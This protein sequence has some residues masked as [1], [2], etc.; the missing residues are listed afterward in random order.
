MTQN[1]PLV[2]VIILNYNGKKFLDDCFSSVLESTYPNV[3]TMML[4]NASTD[5]SVAY[6][7]AKYPA[8]KIVENPHNNGYSNGYNL[9]FKHAKGKYFVLLNN[10]VKVAKDWLEPL[11]EAAEQDEEIAAL[12]P[13]LVSMIDPSNFE[14][15]GASGGMM[16]RYGYP[17]T[18]GR[19]FD[20][21]EKDEGQYDD[22]TEIF[23]ASGAALFLRADVIKNCGDLDADFVHHMEEIDFCWRMHLAGYKI[24]VVPKSLVLHYG[25]A[26]ISPDS[27]KKM[28]WNHRNSTFMLFKNVGAENFYR[29]LFMKWWLD[30]IT[31]ST[32]FLK[33]DFKRT[34]AVISGHFWLFFHWGLIAR[35]RKEVQSNRKVKDAVVFKKLYPKSIALD[36]FTKKVRTFSDL[37]WKIA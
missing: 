17:F 30:F 32:S 36:Y 35:K 12:Q 29:I 33:L 6:T 21:M 4:D 2:S 34:R 37:K 13:K 23:W 9:S 14:Y 20:H 28:Y 8:V 15:A 19:L 22:E 16:D 3:E 11:V 25:G 24:K 1:L 10:D 18:R 31:I 7:R 5:D 26:T 27:Y